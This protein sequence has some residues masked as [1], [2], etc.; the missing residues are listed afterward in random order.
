MK[1][2]IEEIKIQFDITTPIPLHE[3]WLVEFYNQTTSEAD[4]KIIK[5]GLKASEIY[6]TIEMGGSALPFLDP[7]HYILPLPEFLLLLY[8]LYIYIYIH[9]SRIKH[10]KV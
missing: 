2:K 9:S 3:K 10:N 1:K 6:G 5:N 8:I 7:I 4:S